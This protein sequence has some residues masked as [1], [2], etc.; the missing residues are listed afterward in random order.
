VPD[1]SFELVQ[2]MLLEKFHEALDTLNIPHHKISSTPS[3]R[4]GQLESSQTE[5]QQ[6]RYL[7]T[8]I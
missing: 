8:V 3:S 5:I 4:T 1:N 2:R 7:L 6:P